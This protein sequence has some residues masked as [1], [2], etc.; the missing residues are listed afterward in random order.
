MAEIGKMSG[1]DTPP[2]PAPAAAPAAKPPEPAKPAAAPAAKPPEGV[3]PPEPAKPAAPAAPKPPE[4]KPLDWKTAPTQFRTA[5][6]K[7]KSEFDKKT[8]EYEAK[9]TTTNQQMQALEQR[10]FLTPEQEAKYAQLETQQQALQAELYSRDYKESPEFQAKWD[11]KARTV[12]ASLDN[13]LKSIKVTENDQE[14]PATRADFERIRSLGN[15]QVEQRRA[16]KQLFGDDAD[17]IIA[18]AREL[19]A[20]EDGANEEIASK[21]STFDN[22]RKQQGQRQQQEFQQSQKV[23]TEYD[24]LLVQKFPQYFAP[25]EGNAEFNKALEEGLKF[26][27]S[28]TSKFNAGTPEQ[29]AQSSA[30]MRRFAAAFPALQ[31]RVKQLASENEALQARVL[32]LQGNDPGAGGG[33][34]GGGGTDADIGG[35]DALS[36]EIEK[37]QRG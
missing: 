21:R 15:S 36:A 9:L 8:L 7:L 33:D 20:I 1:S 37:L 31:V 25:I 34:G 17:V 23:F 22:D 26:V 16:A 35:T 29:K 28:S 3:K 27:D 12:Y 2:A 5:F 30:M 18:A 32:K 10:K 13:E 19:K 6:D 11:S 14:R 24:G 4:E